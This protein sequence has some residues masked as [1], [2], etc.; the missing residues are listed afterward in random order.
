MSDV[1]L[2]LLAAGGSRRLGRPKQLLAFGGRTLVHHTA[3]A[4]LATPCRPLLVVLGA[5]RDRTAAALVGLPVRI[6]DNRRWAEGI[7]TS[8]AAGIAAAAAHGAAGAVLALADQPRVTAAS[9][10]RLLAAR[11]ATGHPIV[12]SRY[13]ATVGVPAFFAA[14][15]F[16]QLLALDRDRGCKALILAAGAQAT[17]VDCPEAATDVDTAADYARM[18][19]SRSGTSA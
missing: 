7:G 15:V 4:L 19:A 3:S 12:A 18:R 5:E 10:E 2:V 8:I 1:A 11:A 13:A 14:E 17:F 16:P 9:I 6:V